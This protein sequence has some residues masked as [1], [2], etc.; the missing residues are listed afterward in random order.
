MDYKN[1][2]A[3]FAYERRKDQLTLAKL[4]ENKKQEKN[5]RTSA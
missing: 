2:P 1:C 3:D 5:Q 4:V